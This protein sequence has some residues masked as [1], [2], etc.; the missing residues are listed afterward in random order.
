MPMNSASYSSR[1]LRVSANQGLRRVHAVEDHVRPDPGREPPHRVLAGRV[2]V[3]GDRHDQVVRGLLD[4]LEEQ[5]LLGRD[6]VVERA[7]LDADAGGKLP[8][9]GRVVALEC[10]Q[11]QRAA[12]DLLLGGRR[13][14]V[15]A[16]RSVQGV[17]G[18]CHYRPTFLATARRARLP[19]V[20]RLRTGA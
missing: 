18:H 16:S 17:L 4:Q 8:G 15:V 6:V 20:G 13:P 2:D 12:E 7:R 14:A 1:C 19:N 5:V 10:E 11:L 9:A 3:P